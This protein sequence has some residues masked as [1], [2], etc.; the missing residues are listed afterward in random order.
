M[1]SATLT[2][3]WRDEGNSSWDYWVEEGNVDWD[4]HLVVNVYYEIIKGKYV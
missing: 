4:Q 3:K 1:I 2:V